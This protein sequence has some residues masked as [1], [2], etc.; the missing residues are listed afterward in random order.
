VPRL[1]AGHVALQAFTIFTKSPHGLNF[2]RNSGAAFDDVSALMFIQLAP[3][4]AWTNL[5]ARA[6]Y[7]A[8]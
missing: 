5:T 6:L 4:A 3:V 7:V 1:V 2:N 8:Y